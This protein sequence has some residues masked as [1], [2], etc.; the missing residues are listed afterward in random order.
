MRIKKAAAVL[1]IFMLVIGCGTL[2]IW[3]SD[4]GMVP[5]V[6]DESVICGT[7]EKESTGDKKDETMPG[8][9][10]IDKETDM[11]TYRETDETEGKGNGD[12]KNQDGRAEKDTMDTDNEEPDN[13]EPD[14]E[15]PDDEEPDDEE[16]D[17][18]KPDGEKP[19]NLKP[20]SLESDCMEPE[21]DADETD[22]YVYHGEIF[23]Q[24]AG[25]EKSEKLR[26]SA[27][28]VTG[29]ID[30]TYWAIHSGAGFGDIFEDGRDLDHLGCIMLETG[31]TWL[32]AYCVHHNSNLRGGHTYADIESYL[33]DSEKKELT[34]RALYYGFRFSNWNPDRGVKPS[35]GDKGKY[36]AT[37][38][39]VWFIEHGWY[40]YN[41]Y[42]F[43]LTDK[44]IA[45]AKTICAKSDQN[46]TGDAYDYFTKL[47]GKMQ[48]YDKMPSFTE[49]N[50][51]SAKSYTLGYDMKTKKY[52]LTLTDTNQVLNDCQ[53]SGLPK[54]VTADIKENKL[55]LT[56]SVPVTAATI[57]ISKPSFQAQTALTVWS[58][59][60]DSSYQQLA[61]YSTPAGGTVNAYFKLRTVP[62][63]TMSVEKTWDDNDNFFDL[64]PSNV[65]VDLY[66]GL[67]KGEETEFVQ[68][69][70]L[71]AS[72]S[73]CMTV[74][75][76]PES[77]KEG[78]QIYYTFKERETPYY[79]SSVTESSPAEKHWK[80]T[81]TNTLI[82]GNV[83][84]VKSSA[85]SQISAGNDSYSLAGAVYGVYFDPDCRELA[86]TLATGEDGL[87]ET[88][89]GLAEGTYYV[90]ET[91]APRGFQLNTTVY[92][93]E[94]QGRDTA[95]IEVADIPL[96]YQPGIELVKYSE[97]NTGG[98]DNYSLEGTE[99]TLKFYGDPD[100]TEGELLAAEPERTWVLAVK[101]DS[102]EQSLYRAALKEDY[103][104]SEK[105]DDFY[106]DENGGAILPLGTLTIE[107][108]RTAPCF[109]ADGYIKT[110]SGE[111]IWDDLSKPVI[112]EISSERGEIRL[113]MA[114]GMALDDLHFDVY[115][116]PHEGSIQIVKSGADGDVLKDVTFALYDSDGLLV[117]E[118]STDAEGNLNFTGLPLGSYQIVET[119]APDGHQLLKEPIEVTIPLI[120]TEKE[121]D[122]KN[123]SSDQWIFDE[124]NGKYYIF[125]LVYK[126][127]NGAAFV[128]PA[129]GAAETVWNYIPAGMGFILIG[130]AV[131]WRWRRKPR[132]T[133]EVS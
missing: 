16:P 34:G 45:T 23:T 32:T 59:Q 101:K 80:Y 58:D 107:E 74:S 56:S 55:V 10:M 90:K 60:T 33:T 106:Y 35:D 57:T 129:T 13:E 117:E 26:A 65:T 1:L 20:D 21:T 4:T 113:Q 76:L 50:M 37:Q 88:L 67:T 69:C 5:G 93:V 119:A 73:W 100:L 18:E 52:S 28:R 29:V 99:F 87:S 111:T 46:S 131:L 91:E 71:D 2:N 47:Y 41:N 72:N 75:N 130:G 124:Q 110:S 114:N 14:N 108:T 44:A 104:V 70:I 112:V 85:N 66:M 17:D 3:A 64:R 103:L 36:T 116:K 19:D 83:Q 127:S 53:I 96:T 31:G 25:K 86:G 39:M 105:S 78:N 6:S 77:D 120:L 97:D 63:V 48:N 43:T 51:S 12:E 22:S 82:K 109:T 133:G 79:T 126:I 54:G 62:T 11:E 7:D 24:V 118:K 30:Y 27:R 49:R 95:V 81:F 125:D 9:S 122:S 38:V 8:T 94:I 128:L 89:E 115:D 15:K 40:T 132:G 92:T 121:V 42:T 84:L 98:T 61:T 123:I 68:T 102:E